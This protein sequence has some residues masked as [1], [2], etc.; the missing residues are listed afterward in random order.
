MGI[1]ESAEKEQESRNAS[2]SELTADNSQKSSVNS[3]PFLLPKITTYKRLLT[4]SLIYIAIL[5]VRGKWVIVVIKKRR[6]IDASLLCKMSCQE[7]D[8]ELITMKNGKPAT[9]GTCP[10]CGTKMFKIGKT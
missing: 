3:E 9:E 7:R 2:T 6:I 10:S 1:L 8:E 4:M 5:Q